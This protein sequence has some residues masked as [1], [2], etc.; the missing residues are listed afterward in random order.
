VT[1]PRGDGSGVVFT[2]AAGGI[3]KALAATAAEIDG[4]QRL[5]DGLT[6]RRVVRDAGV[7]S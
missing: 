4:V 3:R 2:G 5:A 6:V 7:V 1:S